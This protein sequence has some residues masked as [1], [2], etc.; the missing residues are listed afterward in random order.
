MG[1]AMKGNATRKPVQRKPASQRK[2]VKH[3]GAQPRRQ[4]PQVQRN[5]FGIVR[6]AVSV[7]VVVAF[8]GFLTEMALTVGSVSVERVAF[9]GSAQYV[10]RERLIERVKPY[11]DTGY[12]AL[13]LDAIKQS[14]EQEPWVLSAR[15]ERS[16]PWSL[17]ITIDEQ[18][19]IAYWGRDSFLN[20]RG[21]VFT[22]PSVARD[23]DLPMLSG[24]DTTALSVL[25]AY[26]I[27]AQM[28][29]ETPLELTQLS[30]DEKGQWAGVTRE[31]VEIRLGNN[32]P[33]HSM[34]RFLL[35]YQQALRERFAEV[36][37]V[38][39]RYIN[40]IAVDWKGARS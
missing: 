2:A 40:G 20:H 15:V 5:W 25:Q 17:T 16:W 24:P 39:T 11:L 13:E 30:L 32:R 14:V 19:P 8:V 9:A 27:I 31:N 37:Q 18:T 29:T 26:Q 23:L 28:L 7:G 10:S 36:Q 22:P 12:F 33:V 6:F 38:D 21:D 3:R 35:V 4:R 34:K 1:N